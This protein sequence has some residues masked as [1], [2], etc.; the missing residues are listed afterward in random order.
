M[1]K[2]VVLVA[3]VSTSSFGCALNSDH[4]DADG[5]ELLG[6]SESA[7]WEAIDS[8]VAIPEEPDLSAPFAG[9][10]IEQAGGDPELVSV[11]PFGGDREYVIDASL[12]GSVLVNTAGLDFQSGIRRMTGHVTLTLQ[13][14]YGPSEHYTWKMPKF[15]DSPAFVPGVL[16]PVVVNKYLKIYTKSLRNIIGKCEQRGG[17][18]SLTGA[19]G[20]Q[21]D[22]GS[23]V[24]TANV[25][26]ALEV[27]P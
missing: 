20:N 17:L 25:N 12:P 19:I 4:G 10:R 16:R 22:N 21:V 24:R 5:D 7:L 15:Y 3:L 14:W 26:V 11:A 2:I 6:T 27:R 1:K 8:Q 18:F 9:V 13:C 23:H